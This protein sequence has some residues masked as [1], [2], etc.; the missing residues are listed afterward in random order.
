MIPRSVPKAV[1][2]SRNVPGQ[3][4]REFPGAI[5]APGGRFWAPFWD[6]LGAK[7]VTKSSFLVPGRTKIS[8]NEVQNEVSKHI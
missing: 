6:Q 7:G 1:S 2:I 8:K 3:A 5:L 4:D